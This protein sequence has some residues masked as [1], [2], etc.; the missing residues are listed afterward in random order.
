MTKSFKPIFTITNRQSLQ[1]DLKAMVDI[2]L[3]VSEGST[4]KLVYRMKEAG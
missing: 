1:R 3:L 4:N 2:G